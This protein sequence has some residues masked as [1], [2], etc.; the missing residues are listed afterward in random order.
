MSGGACPG[1]VTAGPPSIGVVFPRSDSWCAAFG[2]ELLESLADGIEDLWVPVAPIARV[3]HHLAELFFR[4]RLPLRVII[5]EQRTQ[6]F[7][8]FRPEGL[9]QQNRRPRRDDGIQFRQFRLQVF[10]F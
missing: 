8:D 7:A 5:A 2:I 9:G 1:K 3:A 4:I 6:Q 10:R